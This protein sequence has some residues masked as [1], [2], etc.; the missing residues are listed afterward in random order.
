MI[1][2]NDKPIDELSHEELTDVSFTL[3]KMFGDHEQIKQHPK[4]IEKFKN[5]PR[6]AVNPAFLAIK[7]AV[8]KEMKSRTLYMEGIKDK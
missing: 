5:R 2:W 4:Y 6:P 7:E 1:K 8:D 3:N